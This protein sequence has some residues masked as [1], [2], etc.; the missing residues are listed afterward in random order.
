MANGQTSSNQSKKAPPQRARSSSS[1]SSKGKASEATSER[2]D[3]YGLISVIYHSLQ[4]AE[5]CNQYIEDARRGGNDEL[6]NFFE[7]SRDEQNRRALEGRRLLS[8]ELQDIEDETE[9]LLEDEDS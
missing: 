6:V 5:T 4:G 9:A 7:E 2:D 3:T 8:A 1:K